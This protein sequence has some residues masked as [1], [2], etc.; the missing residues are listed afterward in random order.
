MQYA[1]INSSSVTETVSEVALLRMRQ[2]RVVTSCCG[3]GVRAG[4]AS[5][6]RAWVG[7]GVDDVSQHQID[8]HV[9]VIANRDIATTFLGFELASINIANVVTG[10]GSL[11]KNALSRFRMVCHVADCTI[12]V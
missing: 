5:R 12:P 7:V 9:I 10:R 11:I 8:T 6:C 2:S 4:P 1:I 3:R